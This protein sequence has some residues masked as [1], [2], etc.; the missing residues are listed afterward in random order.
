M[1]LGSNPSSLPQE[2]AYELSKSKTAKIK[3]IMNLL[4]PWNAQNAKLPQIGDSF[5]NTAKVH[6]FFS[7]T[8]NVSGKI[9]IY[10]DPNFINA[11]T[12]TQTSFIYCNN[13]TLTGTVAL[14][15]AVFSAGG[16]QSAP[17]PPTTTVLKTRLVS[18]GMKVTPKV[19]NLNYVATALS[20][21]DYGDYED[22]PFNGTGLAETPD[23][24]AYTVFANVLNGNGATKFNLNNPG[25]SICYRWFPVDPL[26]DI[27]VETGNYIVDQN[28]K[29][30]GGS[31]RFV[32]VITDLPASAPVDI[33]IC[34]N[35]EYLSAPQAKPWLGYSPP[36]TDLMSHMMA[37]S[38]IS[39]KP[40]IALNGFM[41]SQGRRHLIQ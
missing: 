35:I 32:C 13:P 12:N 41:D 16:A 8:A 22:K 17:T 2:I 18:A 7:I 14:V 21:I 33:E 40:M 38:E 6:S 29:D 39:T 24:Q 9:L 11:P 1:M 10:F 4:D 19:S 20:C 26:S 5:S 28:T 30:A 23:I 15:G 27:Y 25:Q 36:S 34:W 31:S 3:H 37:K